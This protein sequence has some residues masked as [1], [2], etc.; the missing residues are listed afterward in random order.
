MTMTRDDKRLITA[1]R[2]LALNLDDMTYLEGREFAEE[3]EKLQLESMANGNRDVSI[4]GVKLSSMELST[5]RMDFNGILEDFEDHEAAVFEAEMAAEPVDDRSTSEKE[6]SRIQ[7]LLARDPDNE[8]L[9]SELRTWTQAAKSTEAY[10]QNI[11]QQRE[12]QEFNNEASSLA[13][14]VALG[15]SPSDL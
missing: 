1:E 12:T 10:H 7:G 11:Q 9:R 6:I 2:E 14:K 4:R 15:I 13:Q 3:L 8:S 5:L